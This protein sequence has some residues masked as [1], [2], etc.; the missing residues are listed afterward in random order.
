MITLLSLL[1]P[2][3]G[4]TNFT[5][6]GTNL[7]SIQNPRLLVYMDVVDGRGKREIVEQQDR[8]V[9]ISPTCV[10]VGNDGSTLNC[11]APDV[12]LNGSAPIQVGFGLLMDGVVSIQNLNGTLVV[13]PNPTFQNLAGDTQFKFGDPV[14][15]MLEVRKFKSVYRF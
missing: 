2:R 6:R 14:I 10:P 15:I 1:S 3:R 11:P 12:T 5:V 8:T 13:Y 4:G 9:M 7:N